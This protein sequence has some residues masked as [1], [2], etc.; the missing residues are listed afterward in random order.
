MKKIKKIVLSVLL[1]TFTLISVHDL[2]IGKIHADTKFEKSVFTS[3]HLSV[4]SASYQHDCIHT[5][6]AEPIQKP[7]SVAL[8]IPYEKQL[9]QNNLFLSHIHSVLQRPPLS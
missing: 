2:L 7:V 3:N 8:V 6:L 4:A 5:L 1:F 9:E